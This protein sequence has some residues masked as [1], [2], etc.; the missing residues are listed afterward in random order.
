MI[1]KGFSLRKFSEN[2]L[3]CGSRNILEDNWFTASCS[4]YTSMSHRQMIQAHLNTQFFFTFK[5]LHIQFLGSLASSSAPWSKPI[6]FPAS[7]LGHHF[8]WQV[9]AAQVIK[10]KNKNNQEWCLMSIANFRQCFKGKKSGLFQ[11]PMYQPFLL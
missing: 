7:T 6:V 9:R 1:V 3:Y 10:L 8:S 5:F 2:F 11:F 4:Y